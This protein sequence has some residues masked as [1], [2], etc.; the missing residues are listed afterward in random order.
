LYDFVLS[1]PF[2]KPAHELLPIEEKWL[3]NL[4]QPTKPEQPISLECWKL[5]IFYFYIY[6]FTMSQ[7]CTSEWKFRPNGGKSSTPSKFNNFLYELC[8]FHM[9]SEWRSN[10]YKSC[11]FC[12]DL[13]LC[14]SNIFHL[15]HFDAQ[16]ID[17]NFH[18]LDNIS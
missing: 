14:S 8:S 4:S 10:L 11:R 18:W 17:T 2:T 12:R 5:G 1:R 9:N 3:L 6:C 16:I 13:Q 15:N 7:K